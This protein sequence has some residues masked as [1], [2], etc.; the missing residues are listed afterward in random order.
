MGLALLVSG[1][2]TTG[3]TEPE[4]TINIETASLE[5]G[6]NVQLTARNAR[7]VVDW[8]SSN[9][10]VATVVSTGFVTAVGPG[11]ATIT[12]TVGSKSASSTVT[13]VAP[14]SISLA[15][16][17]VALSGRAGAAS[18]VTQSV[19]ITNGGPGT[20]QGLA[21]GGITY[22]GG[23]T[24]GWLTAT[25]SA[26]SATASQSA[27]LQLSAAASGLTP[28]VYTANV[29][30][31]ASPAANSPQTVAVTFTVAQPPTIVLSA[32]TA[33]M[34]ATLGGATPAP[35][36]IAVTSGAAL[37]AIG[38][39]TSIAY[40][41]QAQAGWLTATLNTT[42]TP[43][44][45]T[46]Q[47][48]A[49]ARSA[50]TYTA[51]VSVASTDAV[52][53]PRTVAVTFNL[54]LQP[55]IAA[56]PGSVNF[57][58]TGV[59]PAPQVVSITNAG[60]GTLAGL[61]TSIQYTG[62]TGWLNAT[63]NTTTA[64]ASLTMQANTT[65]LAAGTY[66]ATVRVEAAG[67]ANTPLLIPVTLAI[68]APPR[69]DLSAT[70]RTFAVVVGQADP[71]AQTVNITN[72][73]SG[74]LSG[75][76]AAIS[77]QSGT[78]WLT[79]SLN[80]TTAPAT[81][82]LTAARGSLAAGVYNA[83]VNVSSG[84]ASNS[85]QAV[86]VSLTVTSP[87]IGLSSTSVDISHP[88]GGGGSPNAV[89]NI[90]N[91][92]AGT[93]T[94]M[95]AS[96]VNYAGPFPNTGWLTAT[97]SAPTAPATLTLSANAG[98]PGT[99]RTPGVYTVTVRITSPVAPTRDIP[100]TFTVLVSL[101]NNL[102]N[103]IY[104]DYCS[105]CHFAGGSYPNLS[106]PTLFRNNMVNVAPTGNPATYPL[107]ATYNRVIVPGNASQ[108]YLTYMLNKA[109]MA[110]PMPTGAATVPQNLRDL[111]ATWINQGANNN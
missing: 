19:A 36:T 70:T 45:L 86:A 39:S 72:G 2:D 64:P 24:T 53:S 27:S 110:R 65:G 4:L 37:P 58:S 16:S 90:T 1:C 101:A 51:T 57:N 85:P 34:T 11:T 7:G 99:P 91:A 47:A 23:Q 75:L 9:T 55:V 15:S 76:A 88:S 31:T 46:L 12:A 79:A 35:V 93:L 48:T 107:A 105:A 56:A 82:T 18:P 96:I 20:L 68:G 52:N 108:S 87:A 111:L 26:S 81:L 33:Q 95:S 83:T 42:T 32:S 13:V 22:G 100:L 80:T 102:F 78:G 40:G 109:A 17:T 50:G 29:A 5:I 77:Y 67:A 62:A 89:L 28:G 14:P 59:S 98:A 3:P 84:V 6:G 66:N 38:L 94:G 60:G 71:A 8:S 49:G 106:T 97:L 104:T 73:G 25:L 54:L 103:Q 10:A 44:T 92:G 21:V 30:V 61:S 43:S 74:T 41:E 69:I 63:L